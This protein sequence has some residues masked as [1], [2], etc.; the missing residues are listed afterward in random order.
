MRKRTYLFTLYLT[1]AAVLFTVIAVSCATYYY[2]SDPKYT[3]DQV[4][5][6][7]AL[8]IEWRCGYCHTPQI[9]GPEGTIQMLSGHPQSDKA[10]NVP[11]MLMGSPQYMEFLD[12]LENTVWATNNVIVFS[13]NLTPDMNTGTGD[14]T[15]TMFIDT[16]RL[17]RHAGVGKRLSYPMPWQ[18]LA[19]LS[20]AD[21]I[22]I[23][24][25]LRT[26]PPVNNKVPDSIMLFR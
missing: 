13:A 2:P 5:Q 8:M 12:N 21:L 24:A 19:A 26:V 14:W 4:A 6:G 9:P 22:A 10:P 7:Q 16:I 11:D 20:D 17:G 1:A 15:E 25:Y 3:T 23:F 18:E